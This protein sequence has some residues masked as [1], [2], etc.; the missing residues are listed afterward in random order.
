MKTH[1]DTVV[2]HYHGKAFCWDVVNE[3]V[4]DYYK[5]E[6]ESSM[7]KKND[8]YPQVPDYVDQ[9]Y[10]QANASRKGGDEKLFYNDYGIAPSIGFSARKSQ[11][12]YDLVTIIL[13]WSQMYFQR[14]FA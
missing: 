3:A 1:I 4:T 11:L 14:T 7:F 6:S 8:W 2:R 12:V 5:N 10:L 13:I 9:A